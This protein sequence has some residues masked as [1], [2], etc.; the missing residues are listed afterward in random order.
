MIKS[1]L[2]DQSKAYMH[3]KGI[4]EIK[5][6]A[7]EGAPVNNTNKKVTFKVCAPFTYCISEISNI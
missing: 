4:T 7:A 6:T 3:F 1:N 2:F 5:N